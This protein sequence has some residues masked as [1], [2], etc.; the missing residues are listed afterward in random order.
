MSNFWKREKVP[1]KAKETV[2]RPFLKANDEDP[3][4]PKYYRPIALLSTVRKVYEQIIKKR[5]QQVLE[6]LNFFSKRQAAYRKG[7]STCDHLLVQQE[8]FFHYRFAKGK[9]QYNKKHPLYLCFLDLRKAFDTVIRKLL[10]AKLA[11]IGVNG[12]LYRAIEDLFTATFATGRIGEYFS[13]KFEIE[14]GVMQGSKLGPLLFLIFINDLFTEIESLGSGAKVGDLII[15]VL[16]FADD[17]LLLADTPEKLQKL[18]DV[19][20]N[21][22]V[23]NGMQFKISKCKIMTLNLRKPDVTFFLLGEKLDFVNKY[24]YIG[25][26]SSNKRQTSLITHHISAI[27]EKVELRINSIRHLGFSCDGL[28]PAT[29]ISMYTTLVRPILE[30]ASQVLSYR[31]YYFSSKI[32]HDRDIAKLDEHIERLEAFQNRA[33]KKLIPCPKATSP[34]LVRLFAGIMPISAPFEILKLRYYWYISHMGNKNLA[35]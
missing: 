12:T 7:R 23:K 33:L 15:S 2:I 30:Y 9:G 25:I 16:G 28:R 22:N 17:I 5:L 14:T 34:V 6:E 1:L 24:K 27:L 11:A 13:P 29:S 32:K 3:T 35:F 26:T 10:F 21:W 19:C 4:N 20:G 18:I 8:L 31:H